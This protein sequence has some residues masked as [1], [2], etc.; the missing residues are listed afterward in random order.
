M[1]NLFN[2]CFSACVW[3]KKEKR[4]RKRQRE[5]ERG[6]EDGREADRGR[7]GGHIRERER[8]DEG[9]RLGR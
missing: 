2:L 8:K 5:R 1:I 4:D 6:R 3:V 9:Q 7:G